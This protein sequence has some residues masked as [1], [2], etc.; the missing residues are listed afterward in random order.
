MS[1][2]SQ[3]GEGIVGQ[4]PPGGLGCGDWGQHVGRPK[5]VDKVDAGAASM[6]RGQGRSW[7]ETGEAG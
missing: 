4:A 5:V 6:P 2:N 3:Q 1:K 7:R